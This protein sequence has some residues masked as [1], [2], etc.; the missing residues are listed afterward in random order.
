MSQLEYPIYDGIAPSY[1][2]I[3]LRV[4]GSGISLIEIGDVAA[5]N[6]GW[7]HEAG[8]QRGAGGRLIKRTTGSPTFE[9]SITLY[10]SGWQKL[11]RG[12]LPAAPTNA[13]GQKQIALV[14]FQI[15]R[16][17]TPPGSTD[18]LEDK[19]KGCRIFGRAIDAAEGNDAQQVEVPLSIAEVV[20]VIDGVEVIPV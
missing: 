19:A 9:G 14:H 2:D 3:N 20:D 13:K 8:E 17:W 10:A 1:A 11:L 6:F 18:L 12:L 7:T 5:V 16:I 4:T 15:H